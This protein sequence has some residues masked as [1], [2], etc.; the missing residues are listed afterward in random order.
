MPRRLAFA[1]IEHGRATEWLTS[2]VL[3]GFALALAL[4]G[5]TLDGEGFRAFRNLGLD[6]AMISTPLALLAVARLVALYINGSWRRS[7]LLRVIGAC[8]GAGVLG[9]IG[10]AFGWPYVESW[11]AVVWGGDH[12]MPGSTIYLVGASTG[13]STYTV[14]AAFDLLAAVRAGAD[15]RMARHA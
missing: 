4:P 15:Y 5:D 9:V 10:M 7:P 12:S 3:L 6:E 14:L 1:L 2:F 11:L 13:A 8:L